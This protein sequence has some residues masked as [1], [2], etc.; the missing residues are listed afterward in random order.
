[1]DST[2]LDRLLYYN[3]SVQLADNPSP[4]NNPL[5]S[6]QQS[7]MNVT[8]KARRQTRQ[9][10][11]NTTQQGIVSPISGDSADDESTEILPIYDDTSSQLSLTEEEHKQRAENDLM[12]ERIHR[13]ARTQFAKEQRPLTAA[14]QQMLNTNLNNIDDH[15][16]QI[17]AQP[18]SLDANQPNA[19]A[20]AAA[21]QA[22][23]AKVKTLQEIEEEK[24]RIWHSLLLEQRNQ[25]SFNWCLPLLRSCT[26]LPGIGAL[27]TKAIKQ[28]NL[29]HQTA[30]ALREMREG[31]ILPVAQRQP[32]QK[33]LDS[34]L[35]QL[36]EDSILSIHISH[37]EDLL[38]DPHIAHPV[39]RLH[40]VDLKTGNYFKKSDIK[41]LAVA[42]F[43]Q[44]AQSR[45]PTKQMDF[46]LPL[47]T[48]PYKLVSQNSLSPLWNE[49][50]II[51]D[52]LKHFYSNVYTLVL[53][54]VLDFG[55]RIDLTKYKDGYYPICWGFL[56][57]IG[58][59]GKPN[60]GQLRLQLYKYS[61]DK[62][63]MFK[64]NVPGVYFDWLWQKHAGRV[65]YYSSLYLHITGRPPLKAERVK[66]ARPLL[67]TQIEE[68]RIGFYKLYSQNSSRPRS[69]IDSGQVSLI[70]HGIAPPQ[71]S[72][73]ISAFRLRRPNDSC[74]LPNSVLHSLSVAPKGCFALKF[75][76]DGSIL[77]AACGERLM[78]TI[79]LYSVDSGIELFVYVGHHDLIYEIDWHKEGEFLLSCSSDCTVKLW[80]YDKNNIES[81]SSPD[82]WTTLPHSSFVYTAK[83]HPKL[84]NNKI[85]I[86][87][88]YDGLIRIWNAEE[89]RILVTLPQHEAMI[90]NIIFT[91]NGSR[92]ISADSSGVI[93]IWED[94]Q[95]TRVQAGIGEEVKTMNQLNSALQ[96]DESDWSNRIML[97]HTINDE[98]LRGTVISSISYNSHPERLLVYCRDNCMYIISLLRYEIRSVCSGLSSVTHRL[99]CSFSPDG[100]Y[101]VAGSEDGKL[102]V[103]N[104]NNAQLIESIDFGYS[105]ALVDI[106]WNYHQHIIAVCSFGEDSPIVLYEYNKRY[107]AN[108][109]SAHS[110]IHPKADPNQHILPTNPNLNTANMTARLGSSRAF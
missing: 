102:Y 69:A 92:F 12:Y 73:Q 71:S 88:S 51:N 38:A 95:F 68:G 13:P 48:Q 8:A 58:T 36:G 29:T 72:K 20:A 15:E 14:E 107:A 41:R 53:F 56:K 43:E 7:L 64:Y 101:A 59:T 86:T 80:L 98:K 10:R 52:T 91:P 62:P 39:L 81:Y 22:E 55:P 4:S 44:S 34:T 19:A 40:I 97:F 66:G 46:I 77:A 109:Y 5:S 82:P 37:T 65:K 99:N 9:N 90:N 60:I 78:F 74:L 28:I 67:P 16:N 30:E 103:F 3:N 104:A 18:A 11:L 70:D 84:K 27:S 106:Q 6:T 94:T 76:P 63:A 26:H 93:K 75:S 110:I 1:M 21:V 25:S 85:V 45:D 105:Q 89:R 87:G 96:L 24:N 35:Q 57:L 23:N 2:S 79:K 47:M 61:P 17:I 33:A 32:N 100:E 108:S 83:F 54:E 50:L 49:E 42:P 31:V